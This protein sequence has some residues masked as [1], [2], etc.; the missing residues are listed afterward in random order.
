MDWDILR[1]DSCTTENPTGANFG[2]GYNGKSSGWI[3]EKVDLSRYAGSEVIIQFEYITDA[4]VNGEGFL[5]D[6]IRIDAINYF[7]D[8]EGDEG[9]WDG[10]GF[11]R[12]NNLLPQEYAVSIINQMDKSV[13]FKEILSA[14]PSKP[15]ILDTYLQNED[16]LLVI[17]GVTRHTNQPAKYSVRFTPMED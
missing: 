6:D 1:T 2:C 15:D 7:E 17:N 8:F 14:Q 4:A 5:V 10:E 11:V 13:V 9:G 12:I 16:F 3:Q